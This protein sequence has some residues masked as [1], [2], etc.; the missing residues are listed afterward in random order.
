MHICVC[1]SV[2]GRKCKMKAFLKTR[3]LSD[4]RHFLLAALGLSE[5]FAKLWSYVKYK[6]GP[7]LLQPVIKTK[8][9]SSSLTWTRIMFEPLSNSLMQTYTCNYQRGDRLNM[10]Y[11]TQRGAAFSGR[12]GSKN[13][14]KTRGQCHF[15]QTFVE[16]NIN[17][18][19][20]PFDM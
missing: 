11:Y 8:T 3:I 20:D 19:A 16:K 4:L 6:P 10:T 2:R 18:C 1:V 12:H 14:T 7:G 5:D 15:L 13:R 17:K 9:G